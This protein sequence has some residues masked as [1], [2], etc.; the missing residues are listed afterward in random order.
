MPER[1]HDKKSSTSVAEAALVQLSGSIPINDDSTFAG[2]T[3]KQIATALQ[4]AGILE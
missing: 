4:L 3:L 2:Y 1:I